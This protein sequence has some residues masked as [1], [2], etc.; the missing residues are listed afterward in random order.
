MWGPL[1][2]VISLKH[3]NTQPVPWWVSANPANGPNAAD[4]KF[5]LT[6]HPASQCGPGLLL[7]LLVLLV[8]ASAA[9]L[10]LAGAAAL[11]L[12]LLLLLLLLVSAMEVSRLCKQTGATQADVLSSFRVPGGD[13][14]QGLCSRGSSANWLG[15]ST[16][17]KRCCQMLPSRPC[18]GGAGTH[19]YRQKDTS[20]G[21]AS[22]GLAPL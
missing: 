19:V 17:L 1:G 2:S 18:L 9:V 20:S 5:T 3:G 10:P 11:S 21:A 4:G 12:S 14:M 7:L 15:N 16:Q 6:T 13:F 8:L 22:K